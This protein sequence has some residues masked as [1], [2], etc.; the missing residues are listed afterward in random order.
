LILYTYELDYN[1]FLENVEIKAKGTKIEVFLAQ[2]NCKTL[3]GRKWNAR[4]KCNEYE[5]I[6]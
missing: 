5:I 1:I 2:E 3:S 4:Y 6:M